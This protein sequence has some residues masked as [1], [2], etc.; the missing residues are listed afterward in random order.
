MHPKGFNHAVRA[1]L[2]AAE[3]LIR[4]GL[5]AT[6]GLLREN[7][8][9]RKSFE[10][11]LSK[12]YKYLSGSCVVAYFRKASCVLMLGGHTQE[13]AFSLRTNT[14]A[15]TALK[16]RF[17]SSSLSSF[18]LLGKSAGSI[19]LGHLLASR[20][21]GRFNLQDGCSF[22]DYHVIPHCDSKP[23]AAEWA[24]VKDYKGEVLPLADGAVAC[25][26]KVAALPGADGWVTLIAPEGG[27][28]WGQ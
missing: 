6:F 28:L 11:E 10:V 20:D 3:E 1:S 12:K 21:L 5:T 23:A 26:E 2:H 7:D 4:A 16:D 25:F 22:V 15:L 24:R 14:P 18:T 17:A 27:G 13:L 19:V 9:W 8:P